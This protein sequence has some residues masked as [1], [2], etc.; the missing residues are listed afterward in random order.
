[1]VQPLGGIAATVAAARFGRQVLLLTRD[2]PVA[3]LQKLLVERRGVITFYRS[4]AADDGA[5][6]SHSPPLTSQA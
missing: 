1:M 3:V 6:G 4:P 2:V 5:E